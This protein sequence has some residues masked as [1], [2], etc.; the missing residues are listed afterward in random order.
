MTNTHNT[1]NYNNYYRSTK[2]AVKHTVACCTRLAPASQ[3][4]CRLDGRHGSLPRYLVDAASAGRPLLAVPRTA[5]GTRQRE[6]VRQRLLS[7]G[8]EPSEQLRQPARPGHSVLP[9]QESAPSDDFPALQ[10]HPFR[11]P[12]G[13][14]VLVRVRVLPTAASGDIPVHVAVLLQLSIP[15]SSAVPA[16]PRR[17][18]QRQCRLH[19]PAHPE[20]TY[21][22]VCVL[23]TANT[24]HTISY[25]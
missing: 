4:F 5:A 9:S 22:G 7:P 1:A 25:V 24:G 10:L 21:K 17:L 20:G 15:P 2:R 16:A 14:V 12:D 3:P 6:N 23:V 13:R 11:Q 8:A 19:E 18:Y